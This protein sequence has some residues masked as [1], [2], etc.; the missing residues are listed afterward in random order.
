MSTK[1]RKNRYD[2]ERLCAGVVSA[3]LETTASVP[4]K[5]HNKNATSAS[6]SRASV[7]KS[8]HPQTGYLLF[9]FFL[10]RLLFRLIRQQLRL[11]ALSLKLKLFI[12]LLVFFVCYNAQ[13]LV[14]VVVCSGEW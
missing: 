13:W 10:R 14:H 3:S 8:A 9:T 5:V 1:L 2:L 12:C 6:T 4:K 11:Q 7:R